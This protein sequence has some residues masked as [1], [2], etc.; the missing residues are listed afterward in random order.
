[1]AIAIPIF[2]TQLEKSRDSVSVSNIRAA[3]AEATTEVMTY[4]KDLTTGDTNGHMSI[5]K[6]ASEDDVIYTVV[7][8]GVNI[9][10][11]VADNWSGLGQELPWNVGKDEDA[12]IPADQGIHKNNATITFIINYA[13]EITGCTLA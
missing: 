5:T 12:Q 7:I 9:E 2:T 3:Y 6:G 1:M 8:N 10:S 4:T 11:Q 13:G